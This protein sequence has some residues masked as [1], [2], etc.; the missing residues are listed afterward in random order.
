MNRNIIVLDFHLLKNETHVQCHENVSAIFER[1]DPTVI[2]FNPLFLG[3]KTAY[4]HEVLALDFFRGSE[5]TA[6]IHLQD[7]VRDRLFRGLVNTVQ[8]ATHH[9]DPTVVAAAISLMTIFNHYGNIAKK[10]LDD[11][12]AAIN[13]LLRELAF[14]AP[15]AA[16]T[17]VGV[18][19]WVT[20][21]A[22]ANV[23]FTDL[24]T[25]RYQEAAGRTPYRMTTTRSETD[26]FYHAITGQLESQLLVGN[27][28]ADALI[29]DLNAVL[30][31]YKRILA[32]E[33]AER[34][35]TTPVD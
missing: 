10:T 27:H 28:A 21:L 6:H 2:G 11:E 30:E 35:P 25:D 24:M 20:K 12:T 26:R 5:F 23:A 19:T 3:Y 7:T 13:D 22:A 15:A 18:G 16:I 29:R 33:M 9:Y 17:T 4:G 31:R 34:T 32:Q 1:H 8:G 14:T